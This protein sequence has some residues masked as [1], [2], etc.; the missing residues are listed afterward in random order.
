MRYIW[1]SDTRVSN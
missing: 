1:C